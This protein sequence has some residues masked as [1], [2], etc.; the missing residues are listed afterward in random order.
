[1]IDK[2][3]EEIRERRKNFLN[4]KFGGSMKR[5]GEAARKWEKEH[6][7]EVVDLHEQH[8]KKKVG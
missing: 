7:E 4:E 1:M 3:V 2:E 5:F 6:P 8:R